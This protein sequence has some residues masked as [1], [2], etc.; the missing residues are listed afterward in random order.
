MR[1]KTLCLVLSIL[2]SFVTGVAAQKQA[3]IWYFGHKAGL[4]FS[5]GNPQP[6]SNSM[7]NTDEWCASI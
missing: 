4:D 5:S 7:M 3:N 6:L 2:I 1:W